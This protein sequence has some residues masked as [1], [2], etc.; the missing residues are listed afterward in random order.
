MPTVGATG[1]VSNYEK[2]KEYYAKDTSQD[3]GVDD[4]LNLLAAEMTNQDPME[5]TS[6]T[7]FIAQLAQFTS[8]QAMQDVSYYSNAS[9][10]TSMLGKQVTVASMD[11]AGKL[12]TDKGT[13]EG[14]SMDGT[15]FT[16]YVNGKPYTSANIMDIGTVPA[17]DT[18]GDD[19]KT[20]G[21]E[22]T[23]AATNP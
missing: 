18:T 17:K 22:D 4:F 1:E 8:L 11:N 19:T 13:V 6:N 7:E 5:P 23:G 3:L 15:S 16:F 10:A 12:V 20:N 9:Y 14:L 21:T 2:F